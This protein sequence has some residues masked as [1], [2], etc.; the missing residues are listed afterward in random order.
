MTFGPYTSL[1]KNG[2]FR[3]S[4][5]LRL[6][7]VDA[8]DLT[9][10]FVE[11]Y[12]AASQQSL[13]KQ[14]FR[15][16]DFHAPMTY[17]DFDLDFSVGDSSVLEF[18]VFY[19][20]YSYLEHAQTSVIQISTVAPTVFPANSESSFH[21]TGSA[22]SSTSWGAWVESPSAF[23]TFGPYT[24][25]FKNGTF[26]A[27]FRLRL[28]NVDADNLAI[29]YVDVNDA[30][31]QK[32]LARREFRR[33]DFAAAMVYQDFDLTFSVGDSSVLEFR[34]F[35]YGNSY[36]EHAQTSV[37][38]ISTAAPAVYLANSG[39]SFHI[40]GAATSETS[41]GA[42]SD[43]PSGFMTY[44]PYTSQ[45][46]N[47]SFKA[48]F[49]LRL[50]NVDADD[51]VIGYVEA[52]DS[53]SG[54]SLG[55]RAFRRRDFSAP[56]QYQDIDLTFTAGDSSVLE[57][58]VFYYGYSYLEHAQTAVTPISTNAA[59]N[60]SFDGT[61][62][63]FTHPIGNP[64]GS[65]WETYV[66]DGPGYM[67][68]GPR[69]RFL[70]LGTSTA[71]FTLAVDN[72][73]AD[74]GP[75]LRL[76]AID[77]NS[78]QILASRLVRRQDFLVPGMGQDFDLSFE[79]KAQGRIDLRV[80][81]YGSSY[82]KHLR[83]VIRPDRLSL[84]SLWSG[85][86]HFEPRI[87]SDLGN[88]SSLVALDGIEY[89]F[90]RQPFNN[91][92]CDKNEGLRTVVRMSTDHG[93]TW[94]DPVLAIDAPG[95]NGPDACMVT[96]GGAFYDAE[97]DVW[98]ALYQCLGKPNSG[99]WKL[100]HYTKPGASPF[101]AFT[102]DAA[103]P[104]VKGGQLWSQICSGSG[105]ACPSSMVDEGTTQIIGKTNG[106]YYVTFHGAN[107]N[108]GNTTGARGVARTQD[109]RTW[110]VSGAD[111]PGNA[112]LGPSDCNAWNAGWGPS[113][114]I[115]EGDASLIRSGGYNY[116]LVE[117]AD[118]SLNC[119][120][121]QKWVFGLMR[122]STLGPSGTWETYGSNPFVA[123]LTDSPTGCTLQYMNF[124]RDR[125]DIFLSFGYRDSSGGY[126]TQF[127]QLVDGPGP[128]QI[129][130]PQR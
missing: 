75:V 117:A 56:M 72:N 24:S 99:G 44:G 55:R 92:G 107:S 126:P 111:L 26:K 38:Q 53:A 116:M 21:I 70:P 130:A 82:I 52:Y 35:Y 109:F 112:M 84:N 28:D 110:E 121:G 14:D 63:D 83:T 43:S 98:H 106:Y 1:F 47:G 13:A 69:S 118:K 89:A 42:W 59:M 31:S 115:G 67:T 17:Q 65:A 64:N 81:S 108:S 33:G 103:N 40:I 105:K 66:T 27:S 11:V 68:M 129:S 34:V 18:R 2:T 25:L 8:D 119:T 19:N 37:I 88:V 87:R 58:R 90:E 123:G 6:D 76:E 32:I 51:L 41:W 45:F 7:N 12:D 46:R 71:T 60:L 57:F 22:T 93:I 86:A 29:G 9:I 49:K 36:L 91:P 122:N 4:F 104:S 23:M 73:S 54:Q 128:A 96:D 114:C 10:G 101:G 39:S 79:Q 50:D 94:S 15:R 80:Y 124:N 113:G 97:T 125:G 62:S 5:K 3:A 20:G 85:T 77:I 30:A 78:N 61:A 120:P 102:P 95:G 74:N 48:S 16:R 100:C 127:Y